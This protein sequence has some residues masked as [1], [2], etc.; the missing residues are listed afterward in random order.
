MSY[1]N[2]NTIEAYLNRQLTSSEQLALP[3]LLAF[4]DKKIDVLQG[5]SYGV[6]SP[7][8]RYYDGGHASIPI[9]AC[10]SIT[11][12]NTV[13]SDN[14]VG[15]QYVLGEEVLLRP[16]NQT[17]KRWID[18]RNT[19]F[20]P[21]KASIAIT[22]TYNLGEIPPSEVVFLATYMVS[23]LFDIKAQQGL[24]SETI[25]GYSR[26]Y[27]EIDWKSDPIVSE[28]VGDIFERDI[29]L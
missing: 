27:G 18:R 6:L 2:E 21:G 8:T 3:D 29:L 28:Y 1:T 20:A 17:V 7:S 25:E 14:T 19:R 24:K 22:A 4:I 10:R 15:R 11:A 13:N 9:D 12:V 5:G 23:R 26:T 16:V